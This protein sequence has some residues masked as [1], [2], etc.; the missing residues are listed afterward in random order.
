MAS[1]YGD[2]FVRV[3]T[4]DRGGID[5]GSDWV[6]F[7]IPP[8]FGHRVRNALRAEP[9]SVRLASLVGTGG[10]WYGFGTTIMNM[11]VLSWTIGWV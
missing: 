3:L 4:V 6:K 11:W 7:D 1:V 9:T 8:P 5:V 10:L 2:L